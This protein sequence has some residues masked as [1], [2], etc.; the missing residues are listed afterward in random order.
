M[1]VWILGPKGFRRGGSVDKAPSGFRLEKG[2]VPCRVVVYG[3]ATGVSHLGRD[4]REVVL[5]RNDIPQKLARQ[6]LDERL[7]PEGKSYIPGGEG[8][9][10]Q[11]ERVVH[12]RRA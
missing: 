2:E 6:I 3:P 9:V 12:Y 10:Y 8:Y 7:K 5:R 11:H 4:K 1:S